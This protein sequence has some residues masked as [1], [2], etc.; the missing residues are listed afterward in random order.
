[1]CLDEPLGL[2]VGARRIRACA[3][4]PDFQAAQ[5]FGEFLRAV[6]QAIIGHDAGHSHAQSAIVVQG[7]SIK[8]ITLLVFVPFAMLYLDQPMKLDYLWAALCLVGAARGGLSQAGE[9]S[10]FQPQR[11]VQ[12]G[13]Y[14]VRRKSGV[15]GGLG[16]G[17]F[18]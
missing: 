13:Q 9:R 5:Q 4:V 16:G 18:E 7:A 3:D 2:A 14:P 6:G 1:M 17:V 12:T 8:V 11:F 15:A 10:G